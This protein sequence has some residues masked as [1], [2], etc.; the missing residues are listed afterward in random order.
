[1]AE[2]TDRRSSDLLL[3]TRILKPF[4]V[5]SLAHLGPLQPLGFSS[6]PHARASTTLSQWVKLC[7]TLSIFWSLDGGGGHL[8]DAREAADSP[9]RSSKTESRGKPSK[10][11][12]IYLLLLTFL[13]I[14][15]IFTF[16]ISMTLQQF[17]LSWVLTI[18]SLLGNLH[19]HTNRGLLLPSNN[20]VT[21]S[22]FSLQAYFSAP[23]YNNASI[24]SWP[25]TNS[26]QPDHRGHEW[27][28]RSRI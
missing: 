24:L 14:S 9:T 12:N 3:T 27:P 10:G 7:L 1:M 19:Q 22:P 8:S 18:L 2:L 21:L 28:L 20:N 17:S 26:F 5:A 25:N 23:I 16:I 11:H 6:Q 15:S 13:S 4:C